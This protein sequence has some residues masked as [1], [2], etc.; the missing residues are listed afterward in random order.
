[1][2]RAWPWVWLCNWREEKRDGAGLERWPRLQVRVGEKLTREPATTGG[3]AESLCPRLCCPG[4]SVKPRWPGGLSDQPWCYMVTKALVLHG[5]Q[6]WAA[7]TRWLIAVAEKFRPHVVG[8]ELEGAIFLTSILNLNWIEINNGSES[9]AFSTFFSI[10][11]V[12]HF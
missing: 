9:E 2:A 1:M 8:V 3:T 11:P 12:E 6:G 7:R 4:Q 10:E 5:H